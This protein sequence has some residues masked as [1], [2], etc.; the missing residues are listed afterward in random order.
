MTNIQAALLYGQLEILPE[1]LE[2]KHDLFE[3][4]RKHVSG[5][6]GVFAQVSDPTTQHSNWMFG[7]R[8]PGSTY[9]VAE[10]FFK[11]NKV[12]IRPMFYPVSSHRYLDR[13]SLGEFRRSTSYGNEKNAKILNKS[14][15]ILPSFPS[16]SKD[17]VNH[18][19]ATL[20]NYL[21]YTS[22]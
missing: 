13:T 16:L 10:E 20:D 15:F 4:Y 21:I 2:K 6:D 12:E 8:V 7:V 1:I 14:C 5:K 3:T 18:I 17:E 22:A 19:L 9:K 11:Q